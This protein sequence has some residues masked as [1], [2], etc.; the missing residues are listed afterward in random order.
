MSADYRVICLSEAISPITHMAGSSGNVSMIAREPVVTPR[1]VAWVPYLSGNAIR[2]RCIREPGFRWLIAQWGL[3]RQLTLSQLNFLFH[4]GNL[5]EGGGRED[6][7][8]IAEFQR[9]FPL[10]RL[11]GGSLPD[12]ILAGSLQCWRGTLCCEENRSALEGTIGTHLPAMRLRP[13][14]SFVS[15]YQYT[16]GD[17]AKN[18][19]DLIDGSEAGERNSNLMIFN[20]QTVISGAIF[21]HGFSLPHV[22]TRE[23]GALLL[24]LSLWQ[25]AG[26]TI[27]G[28]G[29]RGHGRLRLYLLDEES[30]LAGAIQ[31]Y[32]DHVRDTR[33]E[34]V[35]WLHNVFSPRA[36]R[37]A[38]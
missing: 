34:A 10:G 32:E 16:R 26:G 8:R 11:L 19:A 13:A 1:G 12:Q 4:G 33:D 25:S 27:G 9:I 36:V 21:A 24:S 15:E 3:E 38:S 20:G 30:V 7:S 14:E 37:G 17:A 28:H 18:Q 6:T 23:L 35:A 22:D 5:T 31:A 2:H 29:S